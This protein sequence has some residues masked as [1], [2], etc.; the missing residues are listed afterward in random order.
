MLR[1]M[2]PEPEPAET[3]RLDS[4][5]LLKAARQA[6]AAISDRMLETFRAQ[7]L[8]PRPHRA[9]HHGRAP[10]WLYP[11][12]TD[13]QL[14]CLLRWRGKTKDPEV[15]KVLLWMDGHSIQVPDVRSALAGYLRHMSQGIDDAISS[16]A[17]ELGLGKEDPETRR[18]AIDALARTMAAKR[19]A[20]PIPRRSRM[21]ADDRAHALALLIR[22]FG[23]GEEVD[24]S[25]AE[26]EAAERFLGIAPNGRRHP[27]DDASPWL[28]GPA[29]ELLTTA[30]IVGLPA[31]LDTITTSPDGDLDAARQAVVAIFRLLPLAAH[32]ITVITGQENYAGLALM[33]ESFSHPETVMWLLPAIVAMLKA[34]WGEN[35]NAVTT[36]LQPFPGL[37]E[38]AQAIT[39]MPNS[40]VKANLASQPEEI[41]ERAWRVI[42]AAIDGTLDQS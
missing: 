30:G 8:L 7:G 33:E 40:V 37:I 9:G 1:R 21:R 41:Q 28:T 31:L 14:A 29:K 2:K 42:N 6:G 22:V 27:I 36:S 5:A 16:Q 32:M 11:P 12:G 13:R 24:A 23:L 38:Q 10:V 39:E 19:G 4:Q 20:T 35:L 3:G 26:G 18:Q 17:R 15:L 34:G 25:P